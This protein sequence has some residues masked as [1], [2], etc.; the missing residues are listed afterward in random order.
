MNVVNVITVVSVIIGCVK[1]EIRHECDLFISLELTLGD[2]SC[3]FMVN[4]YFKILRFAKNM[5]HKNMSLY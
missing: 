5:L 2:V 1:A 3:T 4:C